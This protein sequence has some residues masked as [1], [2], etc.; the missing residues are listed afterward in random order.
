MDENK[1]KG[2]KLLV[3]C[4]NCKNKTNHTVVVSA[5]SQGSEYYDE[6]AT[7]FWID[8]YQVIQCLGC[9]IISFRHLN[10]FSESFNP[11]FGENGL[12]E[13]LYPKR[14]DDFRPTK[15]FYN[16]PTNLRRIYRETIDC[17]N[18]ESFTLCS[19]GLRAIVEGVCAEQKVKDGEISY[20]NAKG[21]IVKKRSKHLDGKIFGLAEKNVLTSKNAEMLHQHRYLGNDS[22]HQLSLP[23][24]LEL[25]LA[26]DIIEHVLE[27]LYEIPEKASELAVKQQ[28]RKAKN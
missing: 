8:N 14:I 12:T 10:F 18:Q 1:T 5:D 28:R 22:I 4:P 25:N 16:A 15:D 27:S 11:E 2:Q 26:L 9:N 6:Y 13:Y 17:L 7:L 23:S 20:T 3:S 21:D 24:K 19:A